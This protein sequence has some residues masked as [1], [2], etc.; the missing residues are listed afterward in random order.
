MTF[1]SRKWRK[2]TAP[3]AGPDIAPP[4][5][6]Y[7]DP[8]FQAPPPLAAPELPPR[9]WPKRL[10]RV[11]AVFLLIFILLVGWLAWTAPLGKSLEPLEQPAIVI[12]ASDGTPIARRG[13]YK[14]EPVDITALP[15]HVGEAFI[16]IEDRRFYDH[17]GID[18]RGIARAMFANAQAGGVVQGGSTITQQLAKTSF[19]SA[20]RSMKR[21]AQ[22]ALIA[23]WMEAW[24]SKDE[25]LSRYVSSVYYGDGAYGIRAAARQYFSKA[26]EELTLGEAAMLA[27]LMKAPSRLAPTSNYKGARA[28]GKLVIAAMK[29]QGLI[30]EAEWNNA[31]R[32]Q[33]KPGRSGLPSG[34]YFADWVYPDAANRV[35]QA[36]GE[37]RVRTTLDSAMQKSAERILTR[38]LARSSAT[39]GALIAMR[40]DGRVVAMVGG[41]DYAKS[42]FNRAVQARRQ[43]GSAFKL[44]VYDAALRS[45]MSPQTLVDDSPVT[46]GDWSPNNYDGEYA[47]E[48]TLARAFAKSSNVVAAR[49]TEQV[50]AGAVRNS[51][52][53]LGVESALVD[54][55]TIALGTSETTLLELTAAY[56]AYAAGVRPVTAYGVEK[57]DLG[58]QDRLGGAMRGAQGIPQRRNMLTLLNGVVNAGTGRAAGLPVPA[59]GKTGTTSDYRDALFI[60]FVEDLVVGVWVGNDDNSPMNGVTGSNVPADI[61]K[62]FME[63][64]SAAVRAG[65]AR[66]AENRRVREERE[67]EA[68]ER[69]LDDMDIGDLIGMIDGDLGDLM[70]G[71][72]E[73][74]ERLGRR[75][76]NGEF[77]GEGVQRRIEEAIRRAEGTSERE[78]EEMERALENLEERL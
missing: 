8:Y 14:G 33:M 26:P 49:L 23:L 3:A 52:R 24:L 68:R 75:A 44:F 19:L 1:F 73:A 57:T 74:L 32:A 55:L 18:P 22:E 35:G 20:D 63:A 70:A 41:V 38:R 66:R 6:G 62:A 21:K 30:T 56:A 54:D 15:E 51:A 10:V 48:I 39:Q 12:E 2:E 50:G 72:P 31:R 77:D 43:S 40:P 53:A 47:G 9:K 59:F 29:E 28:R 46:L 17:M 78:I 76:S 45:G 11:L 5:A 61:W 4:P 36:Y 37:T 60:G 67:A 25:I 69:Q 16:A 58:W 71:N 65:H 64:N 42:S 27:G 13:M 7:G 34:S